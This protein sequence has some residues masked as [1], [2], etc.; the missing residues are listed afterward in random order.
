MRVLLCL[1]LLAGLEFLCRSHG[2]DIPLP[3][4]RQ[5]VAASD[6]TSQL[7]QDDPDV[8]EQSSGSDNSIRGVLHNIT[9]LGHTLDSSMMIMCCVVLC[10]GVGLCV[11]SFKLATRPTVPAS[12]PPLYAHETP[13]SPVP[14]LSSGDV[15]LPIDTSMMWSGGVGVPL[16]ESPSPCSS[17]LSGS[18]ADDLSG[19]HVSPLLSS[20]SSDLSPEYPVF[21]DS[22]M[23]QMFNPNDFALTVEP[24]SKPPNV[25]T[26]DRLF[27]PYAAAPAGPAAAVP[28]AY[29]ACLAAA[30]P[31]SPAFLPAAVSVPD[32]LQL[33]A[34]DPDC[35]EFP[36]AWALPCG[37]VMLTPWMS[38][39][40][41]QRLRASVGLT[42]MFFPPSTNQKKRKIVMGAEEEK[43]FVGMEWSD[44]AGW[45]HVGIRLVAACRSAAYG[46]EHLPDAWVAFRDTSCSP[47]TQDVAQFSRLPQVWTDSPFFDYRPVPGLAVPKRRDP[48][49]KTRFPY[50]DLKKRL[51]DDC[52]GSYIPSALSSAFLEY[53][54]RADFDRP[55]TEPGFVAQL[56]V[57]SPPFIVRSNLRKGAKIDNAIVPKDSAPVGSKKRP[58]PDVPVLPLVSS[59]GMTPLCVP[60]TPGLSTKQMELPAWESSMPAGVL[61]VESTPVHLSGT[62]SSATPCTGFR[63]S[64]FC[65]HCSHEFAIDDNF[66]ELCATS[67]RVVKLHEPGAPCTSRCL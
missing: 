50:V 1:F 12:P 13:T 56:A 42:G 33:L 29:A 10:L 2:F 37:Y 5:A 39:S 48:L 11:T 47:V 23:L 4:N 31:A 60:P 38:A 15:L 8:P 26:F 17:P 46:R 6:R 53:R 45:R 59:G 34:Y 7:A 58:A 20:D 64:R 28:P 3:E 24:I 52:A 66:C 51:G 9:F 35:R 61:C 16:L 44:A 40:D 22:E 27:A 30:I 14:L 21:D 25:S 36:C 63:K 41:A 57:L 62:P 18:S 49:P 65:A 54:V 55:H 19:G 67:R 32:V 43:G